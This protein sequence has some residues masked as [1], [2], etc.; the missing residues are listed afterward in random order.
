MRKKFFSLTIVSCITAVLLLSSCSVEWSEK[1]HSFFG[2]LKGHIMYN[3]SQDNRDKSEEKFK[4]LITAI[5]SE[6]PDAVQSLFSDK[7][8][9]DVKGFNDSIKELIVFYNGKLVSYDD[10]FPVHSSK[11]KNDGISIVYTEGSF[12]VET[13]EDKYRIAF[14][15]YMEDDTDPDNIGISSLYIIRTE[16]SPLKSYSYWGDGDFSPGIHFNKIYIPTDD[17]TNIVTE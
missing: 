2:N 6:D 14:R 8:V 16:D 9:N 3:I 11:E 10:E 7:V 13:T 15:M 5:E 12:D 1:A 17:T 4:Q